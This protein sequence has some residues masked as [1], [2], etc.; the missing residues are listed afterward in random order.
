M[1]SECD[2]AFLRTLP[3]RLYSRDVVGR[4]GRLHHDRC[5]GLEIIRRRSLLNYYPEENGID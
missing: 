2:L 5:G 1:W 4:G 3:S